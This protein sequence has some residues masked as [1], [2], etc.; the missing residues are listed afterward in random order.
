MESILGA[1]CRQ[2][3]SRGFGPWERLNFR[4]QQQQ[5]HG[6]WGPDRI[7]SVAALRRSKEERTGVIGRMP[8]GVGG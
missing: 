1:S 2:A 5:Q 4:L 3:S 6:P 7:P 8:E